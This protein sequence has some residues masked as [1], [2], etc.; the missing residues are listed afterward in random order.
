MDGFRA[1]DRPGITG[2]IEGAFDAIGAVLRGM[3][4]AGNQALPGGLFCADLRA[5]GRRSLDAGDEWV[6]TAAPRRYLRIPTIRSR[7]VAD[8]DQPG[9]PPRGHGSSGNRRCGALLPKP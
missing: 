1:V 5:A 4:N 7:S 9:P 3:V 8:T 6:S 2:L